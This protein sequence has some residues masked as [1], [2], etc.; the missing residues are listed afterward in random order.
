MLT[1]EGRPLAVELYPLLTLVRVEESVQLPDAFTLRF[2]DP[3]FELFDRGLFTLGTR[4][5]IALRAESEP[6]TV[7]SG[8]VTAISV[9]PGAA[10]RHELVLTGL[11]VTH[12]LARGPKTR[13]FLQMTD[14]DIA[15]Q[16]AADHQLDTDIAPTGEV[17]DYVLQASQT[18]YAFLRQRADRIGFD[19]W[20]S[21]HT[22]YFKPRPRSA[23]TPPVL[24]WGANLHTF[25]VRFSSTDR[26]EEVTVR[27]WDPIAKR[28]VVGRAT[29]GDFGTTAPAAAELAD[30][31]RHAF[32]SVARFAGQFPVSTQAEADALATSLLHR[33]SGGEVLLRGE[34]QGDPLL[35]AGAEVS[36]EQVGRRLAGRYRLT[37]V[38][39]LY[40]TSRPYVT[41][42]VSGGKDPSGIAD[43]LG[44]PPAEG[45]RG[46]GS[47][48][49]GVVTNNDDAERLG[50][51]K[52][53]FPTLSEG[54]ESAWA[55]LVAP[56]GG[57]QRGLQCLPEVGDEVLLGFEL[58]DKRRPLVLGGLWSREDLP[59]DPQV[60]SG[61][62]TLARVWRS[63]NGHGLELRDADQSAVNLDLGDA[64]C[65]LHLTKAE[66]AL[67]GEDKLVVKADRIEIR[68]AA[69]LALSGSQVEISADSEL[70]LAGQPIKLNSP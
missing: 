70:K 5:D 32:G 2:D 66:T 53:T 58:D 21:D 33:A 48:V 65:F 41:R 11:D 13:S 45:R 64:G 35:T 29:E 22:L 60:V 62:K 63:R 56:G 44:S 46:W 30:S 27:G 50:R 16:I 37:S 8:E 31:A 18:D 9:E 14:A 57:P 20:I 4:L 40:G 25:K 12:R 23:T 68:A 38:E 42:F 34:A 49:V 3:H 61:G 19:L 39:H 7:T 43:L 67:Q 47:L 15:V 52:V 69:K 51:V 17:H 36:I 54:D 24:R 10:G 28:A 6:V 1:V 26:C 59:P 55:R